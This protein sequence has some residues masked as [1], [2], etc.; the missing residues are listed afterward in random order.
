MDRLDADATADAVRVLRD[1]TDWELTPQGWERAEVFL[2]RIATALADAD[3][4]SL[5][6]AV[7]GLESSG[8][9]KALRIG[10]DDV[11]GIPPQVLERQMTLVH[12]LVDAPADEPPE[13][14]RAR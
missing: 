6:R 11:G 7:A 4:Y 13:D 2:D 14:G 1:L 5:R 9:I 10:S 8:R 3:A 12:A